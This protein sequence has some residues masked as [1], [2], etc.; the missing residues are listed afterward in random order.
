MKYVVWVGRPIHWGL[1]W[2]HES[3]LLEGDLRMDNILVFQGINEPRLKI[4]DLGS[5]VQLDSDGMDSKTRIQLCL[6]THKYA[7]PEML[8]AGYTLSD[9]IL[10]A[11]I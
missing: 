3:M 8:L 1:A 6:T 9:V 2:L 5:V 11:D 10:A 7:G 4:G